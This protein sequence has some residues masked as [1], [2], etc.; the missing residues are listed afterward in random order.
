MAVDESLGN[1]SHVSRNQYVSIPLQQ[2]TNE[3]THERNIVTFLTTFTVTKYFP[4]EQINV[5]PVK[6][7]NADV[8]EVYLKT[9]TKRFSVSI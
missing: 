9:L 6:Q 5:F 7:K 1:F 8:K 4:N 2:D 3:L